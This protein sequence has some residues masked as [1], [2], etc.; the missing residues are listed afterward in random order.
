MKS[1]KDKMVSREV[2]ELR[3]ELQKKNEIIE[4]LLKHDNLTGLPNW[5][6]TKNFMESRLKGEYNPVGLLCVDFDSFKVFNQTYGYL[7]GDLLLAQ[8]GSRV[9]ECVQIEEGL[10]GRLNGEAFLVVLLQTTPERMRE[11]SEKIFSIVSALTVDLPDTARVNA[12]LTVSIGGALWNRAE[13][14]SPY[15]LLRQADFAMCRAK[16]GGRGQYVLIE[17]NQAS[18]ITQGIQNAEMAMRLAVEIRGALEMKQ[19]EPFYQPLYSVKEQLPVTAEALV[20]WR[21]P[22][23]GVLSPDRFLPLF[24]N[25]GLIVK[26]DL[27]MFECNC[28]NI[29][30][31]LDEGLNVLP[32][33]C[34]FSRLHFLNEGFAD[35]LLEFT[36]KYRVAT[37]NLGIEITE[38]MLVEDAQVIIEQMHK[39]RAL[40]FSVAMD[41]FGAGYS[42]FGMLQELPVDT[43]KLDSMFFQRNLSD[44]K[45]TSII[46]AI[47]AIAKALGM[48]VICEGIE[49]EAQVA[50][51]RT[52]ECDEIQGFYFAR[53]ME[54]AEFSK[55][56]CV[57]GGISAGSAARANL[58]RIFIEKIFDAFYVS[59]DFEQFASI[60]SSDAEWHDLYFK[61]A[62]QGIDEIKKYFEQNIAGKKL[63]IIYRSITPHRADHFT[64][65]SGEA[66]LVDE[67]L[68]P[69]M[70]TNFYFAANCVPDGE[71][72]KLTK[73]TMDLIRADSYVNL[74]RAQN[75]IRIGQ[76]KQLNEEEELSAYYSMLPLGIIRYELTADMVITYMNQAM[77]DIIGYTREQFW[78]EMGGNLRQIVHPDD[79]NLI[80]Q[81]S[82][83]MIE[84]ENIPP[85]VY[86]F[87]RRDKTISTVVYYQCTVAATDKRPLIQSMYISLDHLPVYGTSGF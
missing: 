72:L 22:V 54:T 41:D 24:E 80:Y 29:R 65:V 68:Q 40:G 56:L 66:V 51:L 34:N 28:R 26:L 39:L 74:F 18:E 13:E 57:K 12:N 42:S 77:F 43:I 7:L 81:N 31:W 35:L 45:N 53:P 1:L 6:S 70:C 47:V 14:M 76:A 4:M 16:R 21:H 63:S 23:Y 38:N 64:P 37:R 59:K 87:I 9:Q 3:R 85:F 78:G 17:L 11:I 2:E 8:F 32:V 79:L 58:E 60:V 55:L 86:R 48:T 36:Q 25:S 75:E 69:P 49:T 67:S 50:F 27:Y 61:D 19:F 82:L 46:C 10:I 15:A 5:E 52:I 62:L 30:R 83:K 44:F 73:M 33:Y 20:R 71:S 84:G